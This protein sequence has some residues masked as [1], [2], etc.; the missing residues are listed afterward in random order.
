MSRGADSFW[1]LFFG[2]GLFALAASMATLSFVVLGAMDAPPAGPGLVQP[3]SAATAVETPATTAPAGSA[4]APAPR[5]SSPTVEPAVQPTR[6]LALEAA[7]RA[8]IGPAHQGN[9]SVAVHRLSDGTTAAVGAGQVYY[10]ASTF[11]LAVLYEA[12]KRRAAGE[13]DFAEQMELTAEDIAEDLGTLGSAGGDHGLTVGDCVQA[14]VI[15]SD[16]SCAVAL[17]RRFD[18]GAIDRTLAG[19]G[20]EDTSVNTYDLPATAADMA[21]VMEALVTGEG[22]GA[23]GR[24]DAMRLLLAQQTRVGIPAGLPRDVAVGNKTGNYPGATHDVAFVAAPSG[25]YV[26]AILTGGDWAWEPVQAVSEAVYRAL[27]PHGGE[28]A[29][30]P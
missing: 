4:A 27:E 6:S 2:S 15:V 12:L 24:D 29:A 10:A 17:M 16:N 26:I 7:I 21:R 3:V 11:K 8:A 1:R 23:G 20:I 30:L 28:L 14:M 18:E 25:L 5:V 13:L 22:I 9:V 19:L